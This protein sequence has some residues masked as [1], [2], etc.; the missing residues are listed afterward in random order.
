MTEPASIQSHTHWWLHYSSVVCHAGLTR[1][2][3]LLAAYITCLGQ[4]SAADPGADCSAHV[5]LRPFV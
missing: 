2:T 3:R 1:D 5:P 4:H